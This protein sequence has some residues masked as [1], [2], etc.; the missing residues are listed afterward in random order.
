MRA[1]DRPLPK[2]CLNHKNP[3]QDLP[4]IIEALGTIKRTAESSGD[5]TYLMSALHA[6][7]RLSKEAL[8]LIKE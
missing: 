6:I 5:N 2:A 1:I 4:K 3:E 8:S 7:Q